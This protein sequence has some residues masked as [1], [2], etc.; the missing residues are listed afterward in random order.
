MGSTL[1]QLGVDPDLVKSVVSDPSKVEEA[2]KLAY[3]IAGSIKSTSY[4]GAGQ[5]SFLRAIETATPGVN[6]L[7]EA[8]KAM[9][10]LMEA[11]AKVEI[12]LPAAIEGVSPTK[13]FRGAV[14]QHLSKPENQWYLQAQEPKKKEEEATPIAP[15]ALHPSLSGIKSYQVHPQHPNLIRDK[16]T[17]AVYDRTTGKKVQ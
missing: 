10:G 7:P 17:N 1:T 13:D 11:R 5:E 8:I 15:G 3:A 2:N 12:G 16:D 14:L 9:L 6:M 4:P